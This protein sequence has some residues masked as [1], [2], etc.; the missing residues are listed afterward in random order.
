MQTNI[1]KKQE[2]NESK[3]LEEKIHR[4]RYD[5]VLNFKSQ[6]SRE[7]LLMFVMDV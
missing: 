1:N 3:T 6:K 4:L 7:S 2:V 5:W